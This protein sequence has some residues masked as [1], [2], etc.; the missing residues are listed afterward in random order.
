MAAIA[1]AIAGE[2][3]ASRARREEGRRLWELSSLDEAGDRLKRFTAKVTAYLALP[4][5][6]T[7]YQIVGALRDLAYLNPVGLDAD[8]VEELIA[9]V[10]EGVFQRSWKDTV[11]RSLLA[12]TKKD[13]ALVKRLVAAELK[14]AA[15]LAT[16]RRD[17]FGAAQKG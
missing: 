4:N 3:L 2:R 16:R 11:R 17:V 5:P 14:L 8:A 12:D 9:V 1:G 6:L 13:D 7:R 10:S 15:A